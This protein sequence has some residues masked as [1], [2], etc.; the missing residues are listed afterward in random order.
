MWV[1]FEKDSLRPLA[2]PSR[3]RAIRDFLVTPMR[4]Q[5]DVIELRDLKPAVMEFV[6]AA[7]RYLSREQARATFTPARR[8][9]T[10]Y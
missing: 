8:V 9:C 1:L 10:R 7:M 5:S 2:L 6:D 4:C 3:W